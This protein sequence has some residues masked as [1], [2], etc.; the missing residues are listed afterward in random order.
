[1]IFVESRSC[2]EAR[3]AELVTLRREEKIYRSLLTRFTT[4]FSW[5]ELNDDRSEENC[6]VVSRYPAKTSTCRFRQSEILIEFPRNVSFSSSLN[7]GSLSPQV[8]SFETVITAPVRSLTKTV[9]EVRKCES[10]MT[11]PHASNFTENSTMD[12]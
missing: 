4:F 9:K 5:N 6:N 3:E 8:F 7:S 12:R 10:A 1:M 11:P 2:R